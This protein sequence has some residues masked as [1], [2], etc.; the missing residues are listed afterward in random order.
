MQLPN[1]GEP[2][3]SRVLGVIHILGELRRFGTR[4]EEDRVPTA[5]SEAGDYADRLDRRRWKP[6]GP[7]I[8]A[9]MG[10]TLAEKVCWEWEKWRATEKGKLVALHES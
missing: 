7:C 1:C 9:E 4:L 10:V 5:S 8:I 6:G 2:R 3:G